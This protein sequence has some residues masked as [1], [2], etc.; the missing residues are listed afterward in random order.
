MRLKGLVFRALGLN[1]AVKCLER[2][3]TMKGLD[4]CKGLKARFLQRLCKF[5]RFL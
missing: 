2:L 4:S 1:V 5:S 3:I